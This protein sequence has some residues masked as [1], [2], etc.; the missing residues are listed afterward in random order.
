MTSRSEALED[1]VAEKDSRPAFAWREVS[2]VAGA[3]GLLFLLR[4]DRYRIGGDELYFVAAGQRPD[5]S[6]ADQ[7]PVVPLLAALADHLAPGSTVALRLPA[8]VCTVVAIVLS[9]VLAREFGGGRWPQTL[10]ALAYA[11]TPMAVMQ[12]AMLST[13]AL[14]ITLTALVA[15]LLIRWVRVRDDRL[16]LAAGLVAALDFQVKWLIPIVWAGLAVGVL[17]FGPREML[18]R[19]AWWAASVVFALS[20]VPILW[21]QHKNGW[22]QLAMGGIVRDEQMATASLVAMPWTMIQVTGALGLLLLAGIWAGLVSERFRPY[23]FL[24]PMI[25]LGLLGVVLG[26]LRPYFVAG[27]FPGL[28]AAGAVYVAQR[29]W[30]RRALVAGSSLVA[31]AT[32]ICVGLVVALP[33][34]E[35]QLRQPTDRYSQIDARSKFFGPSGWESLVAGVAEAHRRAPANGETVIV[36]QNY[37]Q[38]AALDHFGPAYGLPAVYSPNRGYG[39]FGPPPDTAT[40]VLYVGVDDPGTAL[41]LDFTET[42]RLSGIDEPLGFPGVNRDVTVWLCRDPAVSWSQ[43]WPEMR[44]LVL[45]DG[46]ER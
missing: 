24:I 19:P 33:L 46:T 31:V 37:W 23:R 41:P 1:S 44:T 9:A 7:G 20:A 34:P 43:G 15:W 30:D 39:F 8:V 16:L 18:R 35:S 4:L 13:F 6:Y 14:D 3:A 17:L 28:F 26:G 32:A 11:T 27:A 29:K 38:A 25:A 10:A 2:I 5:V 40:T 21:W 42:T 22:P 12:S 45:V 36:T